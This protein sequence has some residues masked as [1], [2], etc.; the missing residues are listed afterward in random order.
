MLELDHPWNV[1]HRAWWGSQSRREEVL[2]QPLSDRF[3]HVEPSDV[4]DDLV[5]L[6]RTLGSF[7]VRDEYQALY[8]RLS[9]ARERTSPLTMSG[10]LLLGQPGIGKW[11]P[12]SFEFC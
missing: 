6:R 9:N 12:H 8:K 2:E 3:L 1:F 4:Q 7:L 5:M 11:M 10:C